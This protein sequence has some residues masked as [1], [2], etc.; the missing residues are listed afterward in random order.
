MNASECVFHFSEIQSTINCSGCIL[1][2]SPL[3]KVD[4][5]TLNNTNNRKA[6]EALSLS[7]AAT[8]NF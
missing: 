3:G 6:T 2:R 7:R 8:G 4:L 5:P 1:F